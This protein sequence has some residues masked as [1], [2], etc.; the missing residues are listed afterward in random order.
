R[1]QPNHRGGG[2]RCVRRGAHTAASLLHYRRRAYRP[3]V[4]EDVG[5]ER[6]RRDSHR[7]ARILRYRGAFS[8]DRDDLGVARRSSRTIEAGP[9]F[10]GRGLDPRP[11]ARRPGTGRGVAFGLL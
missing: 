7:P 5:D 4:G 8:W 3:A 1:P 9:W 10:G 11:E 6:L 2:R